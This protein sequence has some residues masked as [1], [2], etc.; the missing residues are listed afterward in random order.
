MTPGETK[1]RINRDR[2][3]PRQ[4]RSFGLNSPMGGALLLGGPGTRL[5][6]HTDKIGEFSRFFV[7]QQKNDNSLTSA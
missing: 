6:P 3:T 4:M 7:G 1:E 2:Q 5:I